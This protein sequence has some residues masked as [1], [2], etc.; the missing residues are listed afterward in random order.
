MRAA[1]NVGLLV[2]L[3]GAST[4]GAQALELK[5]LL[6]QTEPDGVLLLGQPVVVL[7]ILQNNGEKPVKVPTQELAPEYNHVRLWIRHPAGRE[8]EL[9]PP[10]HYEGPGQIHALEPGKFVF[11]FAKIFYTSQGPLFR[12]PGWHS[13]RGLYVFRGVTA[14]S[15]VLSFRVIAPDD[16]AEHQQAMLLVQDEASLFMYF[17][18]GSHLKRGLAWLQSAADLKPDSLLAGYAWYAL[19]RNLTRDSYDN[20][21]RSWS[22]ADLRTSIE[23]LSKAKRAPLSPYYTKQTYLGLIYAYDKIGLK[24]EAT[25]LANEYV[26]RTSKETSKKW[27][28]TSF[29]RDVSTILPDFS[30]DRPP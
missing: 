5:L 8:E 14:E 19:G 27:Y 10:V 9:R 29:D 21:E 23:Y 13:V 1:C 24:K 4:T 6:A 17:D 28:L 11:D 22:P 2:F 18:G 20:R 3:L 26:Q 25:A 16:P 15:S 30:R 7:V 12:E